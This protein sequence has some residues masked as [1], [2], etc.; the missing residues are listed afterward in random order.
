MCFL[1][2]TVQLLHIFCHATASHTFEDMC[3]DPLV[4]F[5]PEKPF[6]AL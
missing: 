2:A 6:P 4:P 5:S 3:K 1:K